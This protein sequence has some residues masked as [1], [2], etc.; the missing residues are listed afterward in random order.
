M[1][2]TD[3]QVIEI[4]KLRSLGF[5]LRVISEKTGFSQKYIERIIYGK[6]RRNVL[7]KKS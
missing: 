5:K 4:K 3:D 6:R 1:K 7:L 2:I